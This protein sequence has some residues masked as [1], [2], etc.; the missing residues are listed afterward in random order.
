MLCYIPL[1]PLEII[2]TADN[3]LDGRSEQD[4]VLIL[5]S[6]RALLINQRGISLNDTLRHKVVQLFVA[7]DA[8]AKSIRAI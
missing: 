5:G 6:V 7:Q 2:T 3:L 1:I 4:G 8:L